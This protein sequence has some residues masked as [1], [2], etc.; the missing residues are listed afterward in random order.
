MIPLL[1][2]KK[3]G[4][5]E[6]SKVLVFSCVFVGLLKAVRANLDKGKPWFKNVSLCQDLLNCKKGTLPLHLAVM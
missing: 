4:Y 2:D 6:L 1:L 5:G 3:L